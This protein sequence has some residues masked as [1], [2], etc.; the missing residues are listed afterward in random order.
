MA[1]FPA[2]TVWESRSAGNSTVNG[3]AF[4]PGMG[5]S[6]TDYSQ[7]NSPQLTLADV[8]TTGG[9]AVITS[10]TGGFTAAM[11]GNGLSLN[12]GGTF[13]WYY[14][15]TFTS[16]T[17]VT[18]NKNVVGGSLTGVAM[19]L[20]GAANISNSGVQFGPFLQP[21][22]VV[23]EIGSYS[24]NTNVPIYSA[25]GT[26]EQPI[27]IIGGASARNDGGYAT[28]S[29]TTVSCFEVSGLYNVVRNIKGD[30]STGTTVFP[31]T[32][33]G[34]ACTWEN[35]FGVSNVASSGSGIAR[36]RVSGGNNRF[37]RCRADG[38]T[39]NGYGFLVS[40][41]S[42]RFDHCE[43]YGGIEF[44]GFHQTGSGGYYHNCI[45]RDN[46]GAACD[47]FSINDQ[48]ATIHRCTISK[49]GR[50][51][52]RIANANATLA[53][54]DI[55]ANIFN[56]NGQS[57]GYEI[58]YSPANISANTGAIQ[59]ALTNIKGNAFWVTGL[60]KSNNLPPFSGDV[61]LTADPFV[62][63]GS[64]H[65]FTLNNTAGAGSAVRSNPWSVAMP[66]GVGTDYHDLGALGSQ[67]GATPAT[68]TSLAATVVSAYQ[69]NLTWTDNAT[70]EV[71][72]FVERADNGAAF[73]VVATLPAGTTSYSD[74]DVV[75]NSTYQ[76]RVR[77]IN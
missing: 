22:N 59:A 56:R 4:V 69:I 1:E 58:N 6:S 60:G 36:F 26:Q 47:G 30:G 49:N 45:S 74:T 35:C 11:V 2:S 38:N 43:S 77:A 44:S 62:D 40:A 29:S 61:T 33:S 19:R 63:S 27:I 8:V 5:G 17:Q 50:D 14:V 16:S 52:V 21:G 28:H 41:N 66:G 65:D 39:N 31:L 13:R 23:Y 75:P 24:H 76:Y 12:E 64:G 71:Y 34:F 18:L 3:A 42:N 55:T 73:A 68:P 25:S 57:S 48:P 46:T 67:S 10:A 54:I 70:D 20:G 72:Y 7:S 32:A 9:S 37:Y 51:G 53:S 15:A